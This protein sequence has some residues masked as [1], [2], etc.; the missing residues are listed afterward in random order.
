MFFLSL[1][2]QSF[3]QVRILGLFINKLVIPL[4]F[5][6]LWSTLLFFLLVYVMISS[7]G[8]VTS[9]IRAVTDL[10]ESLEERVVRA[11]MGAMREVL[12]FLQSG[13]SPLPKKVCSKHPS[14]F[15][16]FTI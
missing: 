4:P 7:F 9:D 11:V 14:P 12:D 8:I 10:L 1:E 2:F 16:I 15:F 3:S 13:A 5:I 6:M